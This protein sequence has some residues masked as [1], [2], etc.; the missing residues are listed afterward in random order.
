M[1]DED[2]KH[3][4]F[5]SSHSSSVKAHERA[6]R[7]VNEIRSFYNHL[8]VFI[9]INIF[10]AII[11]IVTSPREWWFYWITVFWGFGLVWHGT[12]L[13]MKQRVFSKEW[14]DREIKEYVEKEK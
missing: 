13:Y 5:E 11:N 14:E 1:T 4:M 10:L 3:E 7:G 12:S 6:R 8:I 9:M 2:F